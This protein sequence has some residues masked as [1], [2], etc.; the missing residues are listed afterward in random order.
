ML[1]GCINT[2]IPACSNLDSRTSSFKP[3]K[4][5][6]LSITSLILKFSKVCRGIFE[7]DKH[8]SSSLKSEVA[9]FW[10]KLTISSSKIL[11]SST[12]DKVL[13]LHRSIILGSSLSGFSCSNLI[14]ESNNNT[15]SSFF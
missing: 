1:N 9:L 4:F 5:S 14:S 15:T 7:T 12:T 10:D 3:P 8:E 6:R 2:L 13:V 11:V